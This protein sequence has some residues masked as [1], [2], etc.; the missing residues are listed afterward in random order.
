LTEDEGERDGTT[1]SGGSFWGAR[2]A[3]LLGTHMHDEM[4]QVDLEVSVGESE[5]FAYILAVLYLSLGATALV[6]GHDE[7][8]SLS[9]S[10]SLSLE[11]HASR[12]SSFVEEEVCLHACLLL[13]TLS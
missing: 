6:S 8:C 10:L 7:T 3:C 9:F 11:A 12:M 5:L 2:F 4:V 1:L 13:R